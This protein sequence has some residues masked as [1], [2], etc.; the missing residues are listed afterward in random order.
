MREI[1]TALTSW[2]LLLKG[3][4]HQL[5][6]RFEA[7][8]PHADIPELLRRLHELGIAFKDLNTSEST[9]EDIFVNLLQNGNGAVT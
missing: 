6:Y 2:P 1:P 5:E 8:D 7:N 3:Q 4:G 9:L